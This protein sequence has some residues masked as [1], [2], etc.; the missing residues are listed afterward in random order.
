MKDQK[1]YEQFTI[2][3]TNEQISNAQELIAWDLYD[4][5][6][7]GLDYSE[8]RRE[9]VGALGLY[10]KAKGFIFPSDDDEEEED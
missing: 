4:T 1:N 9:I 10:G 8:Y 3:L 2:K 5:W 6:F 7:Q